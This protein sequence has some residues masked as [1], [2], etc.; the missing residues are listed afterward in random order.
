MQQKLHISTSLRAPLAPCAPQTSPFRH[1]ASGRCSSTA[2]RRLTCRCAAQQQPNL[3]TDE[4]AAS[5]RRTVLQAAASIAALAAAG[6]AAARVEGYTP[7]EAL[8]GKDYGKARM[9]WACII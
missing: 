2:A 5:S 8:K 4:N 3:Q 9:R 6:P 1:P 7:M